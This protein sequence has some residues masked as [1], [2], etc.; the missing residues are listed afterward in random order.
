M[1]K[2]IHSIVN[3]ENMEIADPDMERKFLSGNLCP[4]KEKSLRYDNNELTI[5]LAYRGVLSFFLLLFNT[6]LGIFVNLPEHLRSSL[7]FDGV[8]IDHILDFFVVVFRFVFFN[9][10]QGIIFYSF[11]IVPLMHHDQLHF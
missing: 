3:I 7:V 8:R 4:L 9:F 2:P 11:F 6:R 10:A 5:P 1:L